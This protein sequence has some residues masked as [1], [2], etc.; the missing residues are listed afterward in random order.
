MPANK[1]FKLTVD[2]IE[3]HHISICRRYLD[4]ELW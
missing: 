1:V 4:L 2:R 3:G